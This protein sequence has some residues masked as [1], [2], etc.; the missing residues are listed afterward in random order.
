MKTCALLFAVSALAQVE[1]PVIG[2]MLDA[3]GLYHAVFGVAGAFT[4]G[5]PME[6]AVDSLPTAV[7]FDEA[8]LIVRREDAS[9][10]RF[11]LPGVLAVRAM[12]AE[13]VQAITAAGSYALRVERGH[14]A[15]F[16]LPAI[17]AEARRR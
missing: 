6:A 11:A 16:V 2:V 9:E 13:W 1:A 5:P 8:G 4:L 10:V 17:R 14:E 3:A 7:S 12:S 15:L